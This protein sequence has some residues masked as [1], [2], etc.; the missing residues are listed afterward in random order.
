MMRV[1]TALH[2]L[3]LV[4]CFSAL[5]T[6]ECVAAKNIKDAVNIE[7]MLS[8]REV[9]DLKACISRHNNF[10]ITCHVSPDGDAIGSSTGMMHVLRALGKNAQVVVP[11]VIR[12]SLRFL[13]GVD[14]AIE[15]PKQTEEAQKAVDNA[16]CIICL[17]FNTL[18]RIGAFGPVVKTAK[19]EKVMIDHHLN[20]E[21]FCDLIIS[22]S[23]MSSA[24]E[25]AYRS[26][27]EIGLAD[28]ISSAAAEC[29]YTG[30]MTDTGNFAYASSDPNTFRVAAELLEKGVDK[31]KVYQ[32]AMNT[33]SFKRLRLMGHILQNNIT[34]YP[35]SN[36]ALMTVS[37]ADFERY[38]CNS[39]D[40]SGLANIPLQIPEVVWT[41]FLIEGDN[42]K[43]YV[44]ARSRGD[45]P[46]NDICT[47]Y[48]NGGGHANAAGGSV[49]GTIQD[50]IK[51]FNKVE[52]DVKA[53][54]NK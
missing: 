38:G 17:D 45:F 54:K 23:D 28:K 24:C 9:A 1:K 37:Q 13:P 42:G 52:A 15:Y 41:I 5:G 16:D 44:S 32:L 2:I 47:K 29:F 36:G 4:L 39:D 31:D 21:N 34:V 18:S 27:L 6:A 20:P 53:R 8:K 7:H 3:L 19:A 48:F 12:E 46:V 43:V 22:Y 30:L 51:V 11:D 50:A 33:S 49:D 25:L 35:E 26:L 14:D 40:A 10:V